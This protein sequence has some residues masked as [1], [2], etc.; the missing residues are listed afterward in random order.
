MHWTPVTIVA[1]L[2]I[3]GLPW[4]IKPL[5]GGMS[6]FVPPFGYSRRTWSELANIA[7]LLAFARVATIDSVQAMIP[8]LTVTALAMAVSSTIRGAPRCPAGRTVTPRSGRG[9]LR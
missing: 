3:L 8:A 2:A 5:W 1:S 7:A 6:D 9:R 4:V